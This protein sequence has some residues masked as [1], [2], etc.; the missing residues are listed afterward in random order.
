MSNYEYRVVAAPRKGKSGKGVKGG[1]AKFAN[2]IT[3]LMND[4]SAE[5]WDYLRADT[6]P[7][8]ERQGLTSKTVKYHSMLVFRR[9]APTQ[10]AA[11]EEPLALEHH[12]PEP[13][14]VPE[15]EP[16]PEPGETSEAE[17]EIE[18]DPEAEPEIAFRSKA[19]G[20]VTRDG[21]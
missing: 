10:D 11:E 7:C 3:S 6:L 5:G 15:P 9:P 8:E 17:P 2:A 14:P 16:A 19:L 13:E 1:P 21:D 20:G 18:T 12:E 4:M